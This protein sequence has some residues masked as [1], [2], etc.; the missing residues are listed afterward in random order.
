MKNKFGFTLVELLVVIA[1]IGI[2]SAVGVTQINVAKQ[3][4]RIAALQQTMSNIMPIISIC[5]SNDPNMEDGNGSNCGIDDWTP[6]NEGGIMCDNPLTRWPTLPTEATGFSCRYFDGKFFYTVP[7][8]DNI[9]FLCTA[10]EGCILYEAQPRP[11]GP[12]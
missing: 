4:A 2:L 11:R 10:N 8:Y 7:L 6:I 12:I 1:I 3:K 5:L 9:S